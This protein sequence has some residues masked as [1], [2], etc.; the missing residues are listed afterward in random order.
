ME[1]QSITNIGDKYNRLTVISKPIPIQKKNRIKYYIDCKCDCGNI[2]RTLESSV[3]HNSSKS[4]GCLQKEKA[5][6]RFYKHGMHKSPAYKSWVGM[7][8]RCN[9]PNCHHYKN[10]GGRGISY[11]PSWETF[12]NFYKDM[13][14]SNNLSLE[15][16][17]NNKNYCK[18]NCKWANAIEQGRNT[19][20]SSHNKITTKLLRDAISD[21]E[22]NSLTHKEI[23]TK[24]NI[25]TSLVSNISFANKIYNNLK[26]IKEEQ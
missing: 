18:S 11:D 5:A 4:C 20:Q 25:S 12:E 2:I 1:K 14:N 19:R 13:G 24:Y 10:Y 8:N 16:I 23:A 17:D 15:R 6:D 22:T 3:A 21:L 9:N 26:Q 7:K